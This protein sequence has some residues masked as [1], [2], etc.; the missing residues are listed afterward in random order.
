M[1]SLRLKP[2]VG[3]STLTILLLSC[4]ASAQAQTGTMRS[5]TMRADTAKFGTIWYNGMQ[6][7]TT[8][9]PVITP[10]LGRDT[11]YAV[12]NQDAVIGVAPG[13]TMYHGGN[14]A[15]YDVNWNVTP[16]TLRSVEDVRSAQAKGDITILRNTNQ[17]FRVR[18]QSGKEKNSQQQPQQPRQGY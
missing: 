9:A 2:L 12:P 13:D 7:R 1:I 10:N 11:L 5:D 17:D 8:A 14:W 3:T 6:Y 15:V 18:L 16:Y 4:S